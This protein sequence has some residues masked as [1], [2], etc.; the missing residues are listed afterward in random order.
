MSLHFSDRPNLDLLR[1]QAKAALRVGR[2]LYPAWQL[3]HAQRAIAQG[4]GLASWE[5]LKR[6]IASR[7]R[8][9]ASESRS[10][11]PSKRPL[12]DALVPSAANPFVGSWMSSGAGA[13]R[14]ALAIREAAGG[15]QLTQVA[16]KPDAVSQDG[17]TLSVI[18]SAARLN[19]ERVLRTLATQTCIALALIFNHAC[20]GRA[21]PSLP[22]DSDIAAIEALNRHDVTAA[23][24]TDVEAVASQWTDDFVVL[25]PAGPI[26]RGRAA[27]VAMMRQAQ[28]Q[29]ETFEPVSYQATFAE[30]VIAG[31][32]AFAWGQFRSAARVRASGVDIVSNGKIFRVYQRQPSGQWLMHRT[33]STLDSPR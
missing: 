15:V 24:A 2:L 32:Y 6:S 14:V 12:P 28:S 22:P 4:Y 19:F 3:A 20:A 29:L 10:D 21:I 30:I 11:V 27:A 5:E 17:Q 13:E 26:V 16:A 25:L 18:S 8:A 33:M 9:G 7:R 23:L 1:R 31:D